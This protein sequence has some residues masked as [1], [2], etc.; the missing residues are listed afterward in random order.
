MTMMYTDRELRCRVCGR[1]FVFT[2][3]EQQYFGRRGF[4]APTRCPDCRTGEGRRG[5]GPLPRRRELGQTLHQPLQPAPVLPQRTWDATCFRC[6][7]ATQV[8]FL[9]REDALIY[10]QACLDAIF[11]PHRLR[12]TAPSEPPSPEPNGT[13]PGTAD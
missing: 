2:A 4:H 1:T 7:A 11:A 3:G 13:G 10:C 5:R 9:P 8:A 6:G 12:H